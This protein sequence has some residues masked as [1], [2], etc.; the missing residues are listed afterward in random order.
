MRIGRA[1]KEFKPEWTQWDG[2]ADTERKI[3]EWTSPRNRTDTDVWFASITR[4]KGE[5]IYGNDAYTAEVYDFLHSR[6]IPLRTGD[7]VLKG[8]K[9]ECYP[10]RREVFNEGPDR[11]Y[12]ITEEWTV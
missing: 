5:Y 12:T 7:F 1:V 8:P 10:C 11:T 2:T 3:N 4:V 9:G 6:W